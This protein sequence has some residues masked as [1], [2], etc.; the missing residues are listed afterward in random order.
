MLQGRYANEIV[1]SIDILARMA[2][3]GGSLLHNMV[4]FIPCLALSAIPLQLFERL[5][6]IEIGFDI[7]IFIIKPRSCF[8]RRFQ[9][10]QILS[11][12][13]KGG[14]SQSAR[15]PLSGVNACETDLAG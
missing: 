15:Q 13:P 7:R 1:R 5:G 14:I 4:D 9:R 12:R 6:P 8:R 10:G 2:I 11:R 3:A